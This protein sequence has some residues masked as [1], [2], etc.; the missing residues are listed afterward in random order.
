MQKTNIEYLTDSWNPLQDTRKG[1]S[2][3]GYHC[4]KCSPACDHCWAEAVNMRFGNKL[5]FD[6]TP[7]KFE[8]VKKELA[9]PQR[10]KK[11]AIIGTQFMGDLFHPDIKDYQLNSVWRAMLFADWHTYIV[12]T[13]RPE[14]MLQW[15]ETG[16]EWRKLDHVWFGVSI[17]DQESAD[18]F[19]PILLQI[20]AAVHFISVEPMLGPVDIS[21]TVTYWDD[22]SAGINWVIAGCESGHGRR[23]T[24]VQ[25]VYN[26]RNQC[27][28]AGIPFFLKQLHEYETDPKTGSPKTKV[29]GMPMLDGVVHNQM[30]EA[31]CQNCNDTG[32]VC[33][34]HPDRPWETDSENDCQCGGAGSPCECNPRAALPPGSRLR[35]FRQ[36]LLSEE[37]P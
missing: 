21:Q 1:L 32:W 20:P 23:S 27:V 30:P 3:R 24:L 33:E 25:W 9:A 34:N 22:P 18:R 2:G 14:R 5:P 15:T 29:V 26:L 35:K 19:I 7:V 11:P 10:R 31:M 36:G 16:T 4:T 28:E 6:N 37:K 8:I 12:L 17:W 13:K